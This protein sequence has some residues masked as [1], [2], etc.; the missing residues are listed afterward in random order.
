[1]PR[2]RP[3][4]SSSTSMLRNYRIKRPV[5]VAKRR[6]S[7]TPVSSWRV[8]NR[9][10]RLTQVITETSWYRSLE[11]TARDT[12]VTVSARKLANAF[13]ALSFISSPITD[14]NQRERDFPSNM[15]IR[16][17]QSKFNPSRSPITEV[18]DHGSRNYN[19][20]C[21]E[22]SEANPM[23]LQR[24]F[25]G[26][27]S[28]SKKCLKDL[29]SF[30]VSSK[31]LL[32]MLIRF[33]GID[34]QLSPVVSLA[35]AVSCKLD[36]AL[37]R[38]D[39]FV[40]E[41]NSANDEIRYL[42]KEHATRRHKEQERVRTPLKSVI[43]E[44]ELEKKLRRAERMNKR[45]EVELMQTKTL[46]AK[47]V[48]ELKNERKTKE[49]FETSYEILKRVVEDKNHVEKLKK[50]SA[51][52]LE[53]GEKEML[54]PAA[55]WRE[56][57]VH[58]KL[59][60]AKCQFEQKN[61]AANRLRYEPEAFLAAKGKEKLASVQ[62]DVANYKENDCHRIT[63]R[64]DIDEE[65]GRE[66]NNGT[67]SEVSDSHSTEL[68]IN[69]SYNRS[70]AWVADKGEDRSALT[71][72]KNKLIDKNFTGNSRALGPRNKISDGYWIALPHG[73]LNSTRQNQAQQDPLINQV[74]AG[75]KVA[76]MVGSIREGGSKA[77]F[78]RKN[79]VHS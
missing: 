27:V 77:S 78:V 68:D 46:L 38:V 45:L 39:Q 51:E 52:A 37:V 57:K 34:K 62:T 18:G 44:L 54:Q 40:L 24:C 29:R 67:E 65:D 9:P 2:Y 74:C 70:N 10:S 41:K 71:N 31:K 11:G 30:L 28:G 64:S 61:S 16:N 21:N 63:N 58:M 23:E 13:H 17:H 60:E 59:S 73:L 49:I 72:E 55:E 3:S 1:M 43:D 5:L 42:L 53:L 75:S 20:I 69:S 7:T 76:G 33:G 36:Q 4:C 32:K 35:T 56:E 47:T 22:A 14:K 12:Q 50:E 66:H 48:Q 26:I 6:R 8:N 79:K 25:P 19:R 15:E